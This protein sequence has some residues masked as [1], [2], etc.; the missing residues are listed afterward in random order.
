MYVGNDRSSLEH[1]TAC[2]TVPTIGNG[3]T[4]TYY[5]SQVMIVRYVK[6]VVTGSYLIICELQVMAEHEPYGGEKLS[7]TVILLDNFFTICELNVTADHTPVLVF[8]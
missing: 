8:W 6:V 7:L 4:A 3:A 1:D 5:C 2:V